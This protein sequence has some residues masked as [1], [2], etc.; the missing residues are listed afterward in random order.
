MCHD[1]NEERKG[2]YQTKDNGDMRLT[3]KDLN[4]RQVSIKAMSK[5]ILQSI[6]YMQ[7]LESSGQDELGEGQEFITKMAY[8][9][10]I[11]VSNL[12]ECFLS[13]IGLAPSGPCSDSGPMQ[14]MPKLDCM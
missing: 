3:K 6:A 5:W 4:M 8:F 13:V 1:G 9:F 10:V 12:C 7:C 2:P 14:G 11:V